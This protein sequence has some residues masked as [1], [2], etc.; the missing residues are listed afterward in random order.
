[1]AFGSLDLLCF[2][3]E[4]CLVNCHDGLGLETIVLFVK[5]NHN[6]PS[7]AEPLCQPYAHTNRGLADLLTLAL[8]WTP[9]GLP[10]TG[11]VFSHNRSDF[12]RAFMPVT[13]QRGVTVTT[14][15]Q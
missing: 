15:C 13:V 4:I 1:M 11:I 9:T 3:T 7:L 2:I 5:S 6:E 8:L 10:P 14:L 12:R